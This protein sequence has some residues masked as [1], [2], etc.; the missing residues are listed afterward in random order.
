MAHA[1]LSYI[2]S[3]HAEVVLGFRVYEVF[4]SNWGLRNVVVLNIKGPSGPSDCHELPS[5]GPGG[6]WRY[7]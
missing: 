5:E 7:T 2:N 1:T 4:P 6:F 3:G